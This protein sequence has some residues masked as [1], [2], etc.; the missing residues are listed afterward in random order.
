[1]DPSLSGTETAL[2]IAHFAATWFLVGLI[3]MVQRVTY[4]AFRHAA[5]DGR[6]YHRHHTNGIG[7][8]VGPP[9]AIE[10]VTAVGLLVPGVP[11]VPTWLALV[12]L[13]L[14][15]IVT[16]STIFLQV[17]A[18]GRLS[19]GMERAEIDRIVRTNWVRTIGWSLRGVV[20]IAVLVTAGV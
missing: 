1:M 5:G 9:M 18:H 3:W 19:D 8:I 13:A 7:P 15:G 17:P 12:G 14:L 20:A 6:E 2:V 16:A 10:A 4:P 11:G